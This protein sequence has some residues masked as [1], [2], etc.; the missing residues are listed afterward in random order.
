MP[1]FF[2]SLL[3]DNSTFPKGKTVSPDI[4]MDRKITG[5]MRIFLP[6]F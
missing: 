1:S 4:I 2:I 3:S 5:C 6:K